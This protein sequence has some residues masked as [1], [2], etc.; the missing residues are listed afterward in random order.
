MSSSLSSLIYDTLL[1]KIL[2]NDIPAG[3]FINRREIA[4][5][6]N[7]SVAPVLEAMVLLENDRLLETMPRK[8]TR[9][10][11]VRNEDISGYLFVR[12]ALECSVARMI[13]GKRI[14]NAMK[15]LIPLA[16]EVDAAPH[17][18]LI[19]F[20][21]DYEFHTALVRLCECEVLNKE[22]DRITKLGLFYNTNRLVDPDD[23][24]VRY[25]HLKLLEQL[26][27]AA[28]DEAYHIMRSHIIS[29]K[30]SLVITK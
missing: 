14:S 29:G 3:E 12:E 18:S 2:N 1:E 11:L 13:C 6:M 22:Y 25:S 15:T 8:G 17:R 16:R 10:C 23:A 27:T 7:V 9:V 19:Y 5:Q 21:K 28:L 24:A 4:D 30:G 20:R 26:K